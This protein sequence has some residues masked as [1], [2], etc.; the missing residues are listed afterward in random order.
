MKSYMGAPMFRLAVSSSICVASVWAVL[1]SSQAGGGAK[2]PSQVAAPATQPQGILSEAQRL[3]AEGV[4]IGMVFGELDSPEMRAP[5]RQNPSKTPGLTSESLHSVQDF[6][7]EWAGVFAIRD[8]DGVIEII[9]PRAPTCQAGLRRPLPSRTLSGTPVEVLFA[10]AKTFDPSL[11]HLPPPG[12][13]H[14]GPATA[15]DDLVDPVMQIIT[16][17]LAE[18]DLQ[19][20]LNALTR[21]S[22]GVGW[23]ATERCDKTG[24][25]CPLGLLTSHSVLQTSYDAASGIERSGRAIGRLART[26]FI[27]SEAR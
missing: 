19:S 15:K 23:F 27:T 11:N 6:S 13:V 16:V 9:S 7:A 14:G 8:S 5:A 12:I 10:M 4:R 22:S 25:R 3:I 20:G 24:C 2:L 1:A 18:G 26:G 17:A 21:S